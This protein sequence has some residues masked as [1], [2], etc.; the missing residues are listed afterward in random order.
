MAKLEIEREFPGKPARAC[1]QACLRTIKFA[2]FKIFKQRDI[3]SLVLC[4]RVD[5]DGRLE[6]NLVVPLGKPTRVILN[7]S[8]ER[9]ETSLKLEADRIL[10][11]LGTELG[12]D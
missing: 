2:G 9:S 3:A 1:Y 11:I 6:L 12:Q 8:G 7:L 4:E 5:H 10:D